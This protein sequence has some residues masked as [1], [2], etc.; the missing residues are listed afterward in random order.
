VSVL[1]AARVSSLLREK[2]GLSRLEVSLAVL[3][4]AG[5]GLS[6]LACAV[7][8]LSWRGQP[9][10]A[11][12]S[13]RLLSGTIGW[14]TGPLTDQRIWYRLSPFTILAPETLVAAALVLAT[15]VLLIVWRKSM[16]KVIATAAALGLSAIVIFAH[17][18]MPA[19]SR[20]DIKPML[21][22]AESA[23]PSLA[24]GQPLVMYGIHPARTSV[25]YLLDHPDLVIETT[26]AP[27]LQQAVT[28]Y[29]RGRILTKAD[30]QM[31][32][33][34]EPLLLEQVAG[35]WRLWRFGN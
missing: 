16:V 18:A 22:L 10:P 13:A 25:R 6:L 34:G 17:F 32:D 9:A 8:G 1:V 31:P 2:R 14:Q 26:D 7:L 20:F 4:G 35:H 29:R 15:I 28:Q 23:R 30:T 12:Y 21:Q 27:V 24:E 11:P 3:L 5:I 19:W 33:I